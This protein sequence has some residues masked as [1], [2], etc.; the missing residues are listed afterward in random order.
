MLSG[1]DG[2]RIFQKYSDKKCDRKRK[3][4]WRGYLKKCYAD[5]FANKEDLGGKLWKEEGTEQ[6]QF[7]I[8]NSVVALLEIL[9]IF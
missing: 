1:E 6:V 9:K 3:E 4:V 7:H 5:I 8:F 2:V